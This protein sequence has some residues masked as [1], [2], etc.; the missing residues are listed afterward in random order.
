MTTAPARSEKLPMSLS[1]VRE[2]PLGRLSKPEVSPIVGRVLAKHAEA[3]TIGI[4]K[5]TSFV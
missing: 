4:A 2:S 5:F 3:S 1:A